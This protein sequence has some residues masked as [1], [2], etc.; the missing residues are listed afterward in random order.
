MILT[1][2]EQHATHQGDRTAIVGV[3]RRLTYASLY[4]EIL[5]AAGRIRE[6]GV[7]S[8]AFELPNGPDWVV[9]DLAAMLG[10]VRAVPIPDF[11]TDAQRIHALDDADCDLYVF[12]AGK[13]DSVEK[14]V[15]HPAWAPVAAPLPGL[16]ALGRS[17]RLTHQLREKVTYT[18]GSTGS[19]RGVRLPQKL[20][21]SV[22]TGIVEALRDADIERH[23]SLLPLATLLENVAGVYAPLTKGVEVIALPG[24][25]V[26][27]T[28]SSSLDPAVLGRTLEQY[29]P[30]SLILVPQL[31]LALTGLV[32]FG[33]VRPDYLK[34]I[35]VGGGRVGTG[36][37]DNAELLGLPVYEGYGLSECGSVVTLNT[38]HARRRG[39]V[40]KPLPHVKV[41][42]AQDGEILVQGRAMAGYVDSLPDV[43]CQWYA[44]GDVGYLDEDGYL[45]IR[46]RR[47]NV[48]ITAFGRNVN[49][50]WIE[51][52]LMASPQV[53]QALVHG[54]ERET[55]VALLW[56]RQP[57]DSA[58]LEALVSK[59][60]ARLPDY[61]RV[62]E[63]HVMAEPISAD[64]LT[65]NGRLRRELA[66]E[67]YAELLIHA[68]ASTD[69][70]T[71]ATQ[72]NSHVVL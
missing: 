19:P 27:L 56:L 49:P 50:E 13:K 41:R 42:I 51:A 25:S 48:F 34:L 44:T 52:E 20:L 57:M 2:L 60:N 33:V 31:L 69:G 7:A 40:G 6:L 62:H 35:A 45:Y 17:R 5:A 68:P 59:V 9:L 21:A 4:R 26:G 8:I 36:L 24:P 10:G 37:L 55:N 32:A 18:S 22:T 14:L 71:S 63:H 16:S 43:G 1:A 38:P 3:D 30:D 28:G 65:A 67:H 53:A 58:S 72:G 11:F 70:D 66:T 39:S 15:P 54:E 23:L 64:L 47:R 61:A 12:A 29:R 46:G